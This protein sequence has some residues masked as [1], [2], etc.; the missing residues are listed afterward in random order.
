M[1]D[2]KKDPVFY[3]SRE[4]RLE[5]SSQT[6][7][8]IYSEKKRRGLVA[9]FGSKGNVLIFV[10]IILIIGMTAMASNITKRNE[11]ITLGRNTLAIT[12]VHEEGLM[13]LGLIKSAPRSGEFYIGDV[14]IIVSHTGETQ[15]EERF[16]YQ[17]TFN[18]L[19]SETFVIPLSIVENDVFVTLRTPEEQRAIRLQVP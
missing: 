12:L 6:V 7:R 18:P 3:Y 13:V 14:D 8:D 2:N 17:I 10:C 4:R 11:G 1:S 19:E 5:R 15:E 16:I 9:L